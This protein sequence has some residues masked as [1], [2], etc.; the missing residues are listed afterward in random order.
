MRRVG[1]PA[2]ATSSFPTPLD[3]FQP[4][5]PQF[6]AS[7]R[8]SRGAE[9]DLIHHVR[10]IAHPEIDTQKADVEAVLEVSASSTPSCT[11]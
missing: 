10:D 3:S 8:P 6:A 4:S 11:T 5:D 9:A 2:G 1:L 7:A